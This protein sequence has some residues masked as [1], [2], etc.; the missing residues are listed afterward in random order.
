[1]LL[2]RQNLK[3]TGQTY[4]FKLKCMNAIKHLIQEVLLIEFLQKALVSRSG[5]VLKL[6]EEFFMDFP[7]S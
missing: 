1:M 4:S 7:G 3:V 6:Y 5:T 2:G